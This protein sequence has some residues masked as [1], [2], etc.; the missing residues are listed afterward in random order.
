[1]IRPLLSSEVSLTRELAFG[2]F[3]ESGLPGKLNFEHWVGQWEKMIEIGLGVILAYFKD[4]NIVAMI[5]GLAAEC[6]MT[7]EMEAIEAFWYCL[8]NGRGT[9]AGIKVL[10]AFE[11]FWKERGVVRLKMMHL[12]NLNP[13]MMEDMY[14]RMGYVPLERAYFKSL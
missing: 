6:T 9:P 3:R 12:S 14:R 11:N 7:K 8:P 10:K 5:G 2:F 1:M 13:E 4:G